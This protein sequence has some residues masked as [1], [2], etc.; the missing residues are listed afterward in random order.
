[1]LKNI[2]FAFVHPYIL[3]GIEIYANTSKSHIDNLEKLNNTLLRI[4]QNETRRCN[5]VNLYV[6]YDT[7]SVTDLH[8]LRMNTVVCS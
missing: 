2:Y 8:K 6:N 3:Y 7:L 4:L 1:M 5:V